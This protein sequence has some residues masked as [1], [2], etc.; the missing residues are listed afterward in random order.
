MSLW[1]VTRP[2]PSECH[3]SDGNVAICVIDCMRSVAGW[4]TNQLS[5]NFVTNRTNARVAWNPLNADGY[6]WEV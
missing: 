2:E 5:A 6:G 4:C 3:V 1:C